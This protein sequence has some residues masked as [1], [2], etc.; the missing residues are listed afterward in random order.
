MTFSPQLH[1]ISLFLK[2]G[3]DNGI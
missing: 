1:T 3:N 2:E